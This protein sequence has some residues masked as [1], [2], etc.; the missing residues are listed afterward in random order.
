MT[1]QKQRTMTLGITTIMVPLTALLAGRPTEK[2]HSPEYWYMPQVA[3]RARQLRT[4]TASKMRSPV[5]GWTPPLASVAAMRATSSV[6]S[7]IE[8]I[9]T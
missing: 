6:E 9:I 7:S 5:Y 2:A 3:M 4:L 8:L 1:G